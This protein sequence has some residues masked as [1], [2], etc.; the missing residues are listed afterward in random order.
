[1]RAPCYYQYNYLYLRRLRRDLTISDFS[2][3]PGRRTQFIPEYPWLDPRELA[4]Y[5]QIRRLKHPSAI[6]V[7]FAQFLC[8]SVDDY[9]FAPIERTYQ[10]AHLQES[11]LSSEARRRLSESDPLT[12]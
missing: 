2:G 12:T 1:M 10:I 5:T 3:L 7:C 4:C 6:R 9:A 11:H 8:D